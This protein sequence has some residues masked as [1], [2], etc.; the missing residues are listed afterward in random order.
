MISKD[1]QRPSVPGFLE[2]PLSTSTGLPQLCTPHP[3]VIEAA[4]M[5][6][7]LQVYTEDVYTL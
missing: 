4:N 1:R 7:S 3:Y 2:N 6:G 5:N